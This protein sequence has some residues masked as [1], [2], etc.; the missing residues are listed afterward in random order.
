M[1]A[2]FGAVLAWGA[3]GAGTAV[4]LLSQLASGGSS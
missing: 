1:Q 2:V 4:S 3:G